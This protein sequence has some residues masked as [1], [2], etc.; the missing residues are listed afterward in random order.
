MGSIIWNI[1]D[2][3]EKVVNK[4]MSEKNVPYP[5]ALSLVNRGINLETFDFFVSSRLTSLSDPFRLPGMEKSVK[6]MWEAVRK[7]EPILIYG[8]YDTD[9]I[10]ATAVVYKVLSE[11][12]ANVT[13]FLPHR[14]DDGYGFTVESV[15]KAFALNNI[16]LVITVDCGVTGYDPVKIA[17]EKGVDVIITDHHEPNGPLPE[18]LAIINP[19]LYPE[20]EDLSILAGV[21]VA[22]KLCHAFIKYGRTN[23]LGGEMIDLKTI[24]DLVALGTVADIVPLLGENRILVSHGL[25]VLATQVRPG[26][27]ALCEI[28]NIDS[29]IFPS[30]ISFNLAPKINAAGRFGSPDEA[31]ELLNSENIVEAYNIADTLISY[32]N[33]RKETENT[34]YNNAIK[35]LEDRKNKLKN[36]V[37]VAGENWHLGVVGIVASKLARDFNQ[38]AIVLSIDGDTASGSGR[39]VGGVNLIDILAP[40]SDLLLQYGGHQMAAGLSLKTENIPAFFKQFD[41]LIANMGIKPYLPTID[42]DGDVV[43]S[44]LDENFFTH[45]KKLEPFGCGNSEP[46]YRFK[47]LKVD[48]IAS[49]ADKHTRGTLRDMHGDTMN[50]IAFNHRLQDWPTNGYV[51]IVGTPKINIFRGYRTFQIQIKDLKT[52]ELV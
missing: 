48:Y 21:G 14:F 9:G 46:I 25:K 26:V 4:L 31:F 19:K 18:A 15:E 47:K 6:R 45:L 10:T 39:S 35:Q 7:Q 38:P 11:C 41:Q 12:G 3:S 17:S 50:F 36:A 13:T 37:L 2:R 8:D 51:D 22:F 24:L 28:S 52:S 5:I 29:Q 44:E 33:L 40:A 23:R 32:N 42:I 16:G 27:R 20:T 30:H 1:V 34:I 49:L 43:F